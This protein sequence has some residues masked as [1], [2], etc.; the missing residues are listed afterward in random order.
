MGKFDTVCVLADTAT[1][2]NHCVGTAFLRGGKVEISGSVFAT[3]AAK[4]L[5]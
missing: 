1:S 2:L 5:S 4:V 3:E